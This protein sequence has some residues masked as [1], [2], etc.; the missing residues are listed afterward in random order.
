MNERIVSTSNPRIKDLARILKDQSKNSEPFFLVEGF[1][2]VEMARDAGILEEVYSIEPNAF[3]NTTLVSDSVLSK[4]STT[5][6]PQGIVG[7][8]RKVV[9]KLSLKDDVV[10]YLDG[11][12]D[13][14]NVGTILRTLLAFNFKEIVVSTDCASLYNP[15]TLLASQGA[16]FSLDCQSLSQSEL[17]RRAKALNYSVIS[18]ELDKRAQVY[19]ELKS[20]KDKIV[21]VLGSEGSGVSEVVKRYKQGSIYIPIENI[22]SLNVGV[23]CGILASVLR[24]K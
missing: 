2:I 22:D 13:P 9:K 16:L 18:T 7:K 4:I 3:K 6:T 1:H 19:T 10:F 17:I 15:K 21:I 20:F 24:Q 14:G 5:K 12:Q 23:A 11:I 8:C